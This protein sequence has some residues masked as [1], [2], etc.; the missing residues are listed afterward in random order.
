SDSQVRFVTQGGDYALFLTG[1][2]TVLSLDCPEGAAGGAPAGER[3]DRP[4]SARA[5]HRPTAHRAMAP[6]PGQ[7]PA[8]SATVCMD[9]VGANGVTLAPTGDLILHTAAGD[10]RQR[11]PLIYQEEA[12]GG[13]RRAVDGGYVQVARTGAGSQSQ[14]QVAFRVASYD[15][16]RPL[17][18]DPVLEFSTYLNETRRPGRSPGLDARDPVGSRFEARSVA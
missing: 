14:V 1:K 6:E 4:G 11:K 12:T 3:A 7:P 8:G 17:V 13:S 16:A 10:M 2:G 9:L 5:Q 18:I 15:A